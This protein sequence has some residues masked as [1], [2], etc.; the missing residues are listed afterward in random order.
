MKLL[1]TILKL[2]KLSMAIVLL[3]LFYI[4]ET[5][6]MIIYLAMEKP[7][8]WMLDLVEKIIKALVKTI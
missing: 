7:L 1:R 2:P 8:S 3:L 4:I 5:F 6:L